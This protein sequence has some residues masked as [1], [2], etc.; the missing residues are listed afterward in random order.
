MRAASRGNLLGQVAGREGPA[1][2]MKR[3]LRAYVIPFSSSTSLKIRA[4]VTDPGQ[5]E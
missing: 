4:A 5:P 3:T 2:T 1:L